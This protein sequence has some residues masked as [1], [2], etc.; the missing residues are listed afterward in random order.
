[1]KK[2]FS[3]MK[4]KFSFVKI[5]KG[6][7]SIFLSI[8][9]TGM[10][11]LAALIVEG[12]RY[13]VAAQV[14]DEAA[15]T[16]GL[17][18]LA[19]YDTTL[20]KRFGLYA[21]KTETEQD[22]AAGGFL[23]KNSDSE[24]DGLSKLYTLTDSSSQW[25]YD[26]GNF[27]VLERQ[28]LEYEKYR[29]PAEIVEDLIDVDKWIKKLKEMIGDLLPGLDALLDILDAVADLLEGLKSLYSLYRCVQQLEASTRMGMPGLGNVFNDVVTEGWEKIESLFTGESWDYAD[30]SYYNS[31]N[32]LES[33]VNEKVQYMKTHTEPPKPQGERPADPN[34]NDKSRGDRLNAYAAVLDAARSEGYFGDSGLLNPTEKINDLNDVLK[35]YPTEL[36]FLSK[37]DTR[38]TFVV[39]LA[40]KLDGFRYID[41]LTTSTSDTDVGTIINQT[42]QRAREFLRT[43]NTQLSLQTEWDNKMAAYNEYMEA[44]SSKSQAIDTAKEDVVGALNTINSELN[45]YKKKFKDC[46]KAVQDAASAIKTLD[47]TSANLDNPPQHG[48]DA[49]DQDWSTPDL[50]KLNGILED[51]NSLLSDSVLKRA[52]YGTTFIVNQK[53]ALAEL[54]GE[55]VDKNYGTLKSHTNLDT[56]D[57]N[58]NMLAAGIIDNGF[59][60]NKTELTE[61]LAAI[62]AIQVFASLSK[63]KEIADCFL[64]MLDAF[65]VIPYVF[66]PTLCSNLSSATTSLLPSEVGGTS[67]M[68]TPADVAAIS[69]YLQEAKSMLLEF[70]E[71]IDQVDPAETGLEGSIEEEL[72]QRMARIV[73]NLQNLSG[74]WLKFLTP[75]MFL[76]P[77]LVDLVFHL[78][79]IIQ[80][81]EDVIFVVK[82]IGA[83]LRMLPAQMGESFLVNQ[84]AVSNFS[85]RID[86]VKGETTSLVR[87]APSADTQTFYQANTEYILGGKY[88][89]I[90]NQSTVFAKIMALRMLNNAVLILMDDMWMELISACCYAAPIVFILLMYIESNIDMNLLLRLHLQIPLIKKQLIFSVDSITTITEDFT[91]IFENDD[92]YAYWNEHSETTIGDIDFSGDAGE[93]LDIIGHDVD[94][95]T[96]DNSS[97][98]SRFYAGKEIS[99]QTKKL[100]E[101]LEEGYIK[102]KYKD[103]LFLFLLFL[104]NRLK[105]QRMADLI[106]MEARLTD[107]RSGKTPKLLSDYHT[108]VRIEA[109]GVLNSILPVISIGKDGI[110]NAGFPVKT[111]KYVGY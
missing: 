25:K 64:Q 7:I 101:S 39:N 31:Y 55:D 63:L 98:L 30:P 40:D 28:I 77:F 70:S 72:S 24:E 4:K 29:A 67:E 48:D 76:I 19:D 23:S 9:M 73:D 10:I 65:T 1:M 58:G 14:L 93:H 13:R 15:I 43:Y 61:L 108:Y 105:V 78:D 16:S 37:N 90:A 99:E 26:L 17:S 22:N 85:N 11:S 102:V 69:S 21:V 106:Q 84:Y 110:N 12:G 103:Y 83:F 89:E 33:A 60:Y 75:G 20:Q 42:R 45:T 74:G 100:L 32:A 27:S 6:S 18:S 38:S 3:F 56:K 8:L 71:S 53:A 94:V 97:I 66:A 49:P 96:D 47:E 57:G 68:A 87:S 51:V 86:T 88:S 35:A 41:P 50:K 44:I 62:A 92:Y 81:V 36:S 104:P 54:K 91:V 109:N 107:A 79:E 52:D 95:L 5:C 82:N 59:Y 111:V 46:V 34:P 80:I 2:K